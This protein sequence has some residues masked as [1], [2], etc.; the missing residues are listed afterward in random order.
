M[1]LPA[2]VLAAAGIGGAGDTNAETVKMGQQ[3]YRLITRSDMDGLVCGVLLKELNLV[4]QITFAHPKDMQDG[5]IE[6]GPNDIIC[7]LPYVPGAHLVFDHHLSEAFRVGEHDNHVIDPY[8]PSAARVVFDYYGGVERFPNLPDDMMVA[9]DK[10]DSAQFS[11]EDVLEPQGWVLLSFLMDAR[12]GLGRFRDFRISNNELMMDLIEYCRTHAA[13]SDILSLPDV[14][15]RVQLYREQEQMFK[16]QLQRCTTV[17][18]NLMVADLRNEETIHAGNR[19]MI[20]ALYPQCNISMHVMWGKMRQNTIFAVGKS[21]FDRSSR[22]SV[23]ML[24]LEYGGGGHA[25]AGTCQVANVSADSVRE[26]L[27]ERINAEG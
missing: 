22:T 16:E 3:R 7:N 8:A 2:L 23:G 10:V 1:I 19:F 20:Y 21:I 15:E 13:V 11:M 6:V 25:A 27:I 12:T 26:E 18:D 17:H 4:D 24:M 9:V 14:Q 5:I